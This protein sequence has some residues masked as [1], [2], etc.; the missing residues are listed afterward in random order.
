MWHNEAWL[1]VV[2]ADVTVTAIPNTNMSMRRYKLRV[3]DDTNGAWG[4]VA[5]PG[6]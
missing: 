4:W 6:W 1:A 3:P 5:H 2:V